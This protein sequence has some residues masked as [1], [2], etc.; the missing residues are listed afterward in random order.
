MNGHGIF[1]GQTK[2]SKGMSL[3]RIAEYTIRSH[4]QQCVFILQKYNCAVRDYGIVGAQFC[5][6][7]G[8][9]VP[10]T[11]IANGKRYES[12]LHG[13]IIPAHQQACMR[14]WRNFLCKTALLR[15]LFPNVQDAFWKHWNYM[16]SNFRTAWLPISP[17]LYP[18]DFW[19]YGY[20][21]NIVFGGLI[22]NLKWRHA[23]LTTFSASPLTQS[24]SVYVSMWKFCYIFLLS[25]NRNQLIP[26]FIVVNLLGKFSVGCLNIFSI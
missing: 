4:T 21:K 14:G 19:L 11:W 5:V 10:V 16:R 18:W 15:T 8:P 17:D 3:L 25:Q 12:V 9:A 6:N 7:I 22:V 2:I 20:L 1:S 26:K 13:H 23:S 24:D